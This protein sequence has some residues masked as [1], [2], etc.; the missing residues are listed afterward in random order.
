MT[1]LPERIALLVVSKFET[2][3]SKCKPRALAEG[4]REWTPLSAVVLS[5]EG[6]EGDLTCIS[7]A[8]G[9]KCLS[10]SALPKCHGM[11]LH[12][13]HAEILALRGFNHWLLTEVQNILHRPAYQ[14]PF[15]ELAEGRES[16]HNPDNLLS[17]FPA[18]FRLKQDVSIHFFTTEAPCGDASM[19]VLMGSM[20]SEK[21][22][23]WPVDDNALTALQGRG[24]FSLLGY[25][26][27]K[28]ARADA[29]PSLSKSC[30]DKL[31]VK[32]FSSAL[33][34]PADLFI[35]QTENA[36]IQDLIVYAHQYNATSY[37]R[38]FGP[39]GR[40]SNIVDSGRFFNVLPLPT[41]F[42]R[43]SYES[44]PDTANDSLK[45]KAS[46]I[47]ALW[48]KASTSD[49][50][51]VVEV[52][53]NGVKQGFK[54]WDSRP[55]KAS[56]ISRFKLLQLALRIVTT[57]SGECPDANH[58]VNPLRPMDDSWLL[59]LHHA[60]SASTYS[61]AKA[62]HLRQSRRASKE[63]ITAALGNW[64]KNEGDHDW[65]CG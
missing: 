53:I 52:L 20:P 15:L 19:E 43:F 23:P 9:T 12:D 61:T 64:T 3:P 30:T 45:P 62:T 47:S 8:T 60:L 27:R 50:A 31:A 46:N 55:A 10:A 54:Q 42:T 17:G 33:S 65:K 36:Y 59:N 35:Q 6:H 24:H 49:T 28:P 51:D 41:S 34:Y 16:D 29:E 13:S 11:V 39:S 7:L 63:N 26:R 18:P 1:S 38:A 25:V 21:T 2:L 4:R 37:Q 32:Q 44:A 58:T 48:I 57:Q 22:E 14:S 5:K 40:L 56:S